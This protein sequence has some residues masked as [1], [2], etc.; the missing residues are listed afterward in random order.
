MS[1]RD[2]M[3]QAIANLESQRAVLGDEAVDATVATLEAQLAIRV[4]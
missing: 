1:K 3:A 4:R 2:E